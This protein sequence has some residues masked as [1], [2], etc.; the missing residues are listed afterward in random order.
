MGL[1]SMS[2]MPGQCVLRHAAR[3]GRE[4]F[5]AF[6]YALSLQLGLDQKGWL[7]RSIGGLQA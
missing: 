7:Q 1:R 2:K 3:I 4:R 5:Q 6:R